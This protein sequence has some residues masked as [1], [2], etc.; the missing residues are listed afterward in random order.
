MKTTLMLCKVIVTNHAQ[1]RMVERQI[2]NEILIEIIETGET[3]CKGI[4]RGW[5]FKHYPER[6]D[7]L[8]RAAV[9]L[10]TA[11]IVKTIMINW[12]LED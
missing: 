2:T 8:V 6:I 5:I 9:E 12:Q 10:K 1:A 11:I 3:K 7:N 4:T